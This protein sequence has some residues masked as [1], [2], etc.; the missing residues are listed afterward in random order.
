MRGLMHLLSI[1]DDCTYH[2][3]GPVSIGSISDECTY[4]TYGSISAGGRDKK[5]RH[6]ALN[7]ELSGD[8]SEKCCFLY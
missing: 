6:D 4:Q 1:S 3:Y 5:E 2:A 7:S 8:W